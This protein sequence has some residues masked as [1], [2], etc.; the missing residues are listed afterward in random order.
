MFIG[1]D[2][3]RARRNQQI[4]DRE[5]RRKERELAVKKAQEEALLRAARLE[6]VQC[7]EHFLSMEAG[8]EKAEFERVLK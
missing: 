4:A 2:E 8:R 3:L 6:Q 1:K 7:K 5:W